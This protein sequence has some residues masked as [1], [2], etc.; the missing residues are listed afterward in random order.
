MTNLE[1]A[2]AFCERIGE[3]PTAN[4]YELRYAT[5]RKADPIPIWAIRGRELPP[6]VIEKGF[7]CYILEGWLREW[8]EKRDHVLYCCRN[9]RFFLWTNAGGDR[10]ASSESYFSALLSAAEAVLEQENK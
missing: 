7:V 10:V 3:W 4:G 2:A 5:W 6:P 8:L 1:R 9:P